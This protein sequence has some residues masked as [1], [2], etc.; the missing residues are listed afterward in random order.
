MKSKKEMEDGGRGRKD[1]D[2]EAG[3]KQKLILK[4]KVEL[5]KTGRK[6]EEG[7]ST[8]ERRNIGIN[9]RKKLRQERTAGGGEREPAV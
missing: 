2:K 8:D 7:G 5:P 6:K 4:V 9:W 3:E 1:G